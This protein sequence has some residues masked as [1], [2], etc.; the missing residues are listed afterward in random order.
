MTFKEAVTAA[1]QMLAEDPRVVFIGQN[2][3]YDGHV[4][5][6]TLKGIPDDRKIELP[7]AEG[8]QMGMATGM[9]LS[10]LVPVCIFPRIDFMLLAMDQLVNHL[11]K[12]SE[13]SC[14]QYNPKVIIR[15]MIGNTSPLHPGPQHSQDHTDALM[16]MLKYTAVSRIYALEGV[17]SAYREA[18][19]CA[20][21]TVV[22]EGAYR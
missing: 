15:T 14:G 19:E 5:F 21:S 8:M 9:A 3:C 4:V 1:M 7:V 11:D 2:V 22:I 20:K 17:V 18:L 10:G 12:L 16:A 6:E 13:M